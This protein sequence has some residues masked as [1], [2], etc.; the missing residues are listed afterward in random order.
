MDTLDRL[1]VEGLSERIFTPDGGRL[2]TF[3]NMTGRAASANPLQ[4]L[5]KLSYQVCCGAGTFSGQPA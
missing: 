2:A 4:S 3:P 5:S 1:L